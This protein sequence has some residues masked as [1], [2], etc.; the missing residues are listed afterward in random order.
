MKNII[1]LTGLFLLIFTPACVEP[2]NI[3]FRGERFQ[4]VVINGEMEIG[5]DET[6][7][8]V[9][10]T[11]LDGFTT[12]LQLLEGAT[13][14]VIDS[15][16]NA[17]ELERTFQATYDNTV[18]TLQPGGINFAVGETYVLEVE[19]RDGTVYRSTPERALDVS[20]VESIT[21]RINNN[22]GSQSIDYFV[23][24]NTSVNGEKNRLKW[25]VERTFKLT[26]CEDNVCFFN[27]QQGVRNALIT[28]PA[29]I[30]QEQVRFSIEDVPIGG[31]ALEG[32]YLSVRQKSL[33]PGAAEYWN[34]VNLS[35]N[36]DGDMFEPVA[37]KT[38]TNLFNV[39][40]TQELVD[41][42]FHVSKVSIERVF[43]SAE[44]QGFSVKYCPRFNQIG[45]KLEECL[46]C[47]LINGAETV[48]P[49]WYIE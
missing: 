32:H 30:N 24:A 46:D 33:S 25:D 1:L 45:R 15:S 19:L 22:A 48:R 31:I 8:I 43:V 28:A 17:F 3:D 23:T 21:Y 37:G 38:I 18:P 42:Y 36:R 47:S 13:V 27:D 39:N 2:L 14:R 9:K 5:D 12:S 40:D 16:N 29:E 20:N 41:G 6:R 49:V 34:Q 44:D 7:L 35:I 4:R 26:D 10:L 11:N